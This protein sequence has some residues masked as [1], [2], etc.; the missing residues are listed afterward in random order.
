M[1]RETN[2][3]NVNPTTVHG[4]QSYFLYKFNYHNRELLF[5]KSI[6]RVCLC[7]LQALFMTCGIVIA[8]TSTRVFKKCGVK[9]SCG[10]EHYVK[11]TQF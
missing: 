7:F 9:T 11:K 5:E 4:R 2:V 8:L 10:H 1:L 6:H 3:L